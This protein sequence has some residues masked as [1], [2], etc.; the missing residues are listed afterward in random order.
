M[1][2]VSQASWNQREK[3]GTGSWLIGPSSH[4]PHSGRFGLASRAPGSGSSVLRASG[5]TSRGVTMI[6]SSLS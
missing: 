1:V 4:E 2:V 6:T 3:P 5:C